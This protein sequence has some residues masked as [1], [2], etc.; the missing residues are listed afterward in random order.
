[1]RSTSIVTDRA[2]GSSHLRYPDIRYQL[3]YGTLYGSQSGDDS[4]IDVWIGSE[5]TKDI[6]AML[7]TV[8]LLKVDS[9]IKKILISCS[10]TEIILIQDFQI[11]EQMRS[12]VIRK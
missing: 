4:G 3:H 8:D 7:V 2:R 11:S 1:M 5:P 12:I 6:V 10:E 9:E